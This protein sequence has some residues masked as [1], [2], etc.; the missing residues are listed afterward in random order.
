MKKSYLS[1]FNVC[2]L[3]VNDVRIMKSNESFNNLEEQT[4]D[5]FLVVLS[6]DL[7]FIDIFCKVSS[8]TIFH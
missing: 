3:S 7:E 1:S 2:I 6:F 8:L 5:S 4:H